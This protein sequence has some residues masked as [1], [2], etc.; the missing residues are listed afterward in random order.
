VIPGSP[1]LSAPAPGPPRGL[2]R[3][4]LPIS[5]VAVAWLVISILPAFVA[6]RRLARAE[7]AIL[8]EIEE[9]QRV[10]ERITRDRMALAT[11][12]YVFGRTL[13]ELLAPGPGTSVPAGPLGRGE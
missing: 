1:V 5:L 12:E 8:A 7:R 13:G 11:D 4:L 3:F 9:K 10:A 2:P 6:R